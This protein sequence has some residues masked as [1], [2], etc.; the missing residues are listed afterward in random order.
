VTMLA[1]LH[2]I[3]ILQKKVEGTFKYFSPLGLGWLQAKIVIIIALNLKPMNKMIGM[4]ESLHCDGNK[5]D[6]GCQ[7]LCMER[8]APL[9]LKTFWNLQIFM[10]LLPLAFFHSF[11]KRQVEK[12]TAHDSL[13]KFKLRTRQ[14][15]MKIETVVEDFSIRAAKI[16]TLVV[17]LC[18]EFISLILLLWLQL[19]KYNVNLRNGFASKYWK[20]YLFIIPEKYECD[21][22]KIQKSTYFGYS[23]NIYYGDNF[24]FENKGSTPNGMGQCNNG[25]TKATCWTNRNVES[26]FIHSFLLFVAILTIV[27]NVME[28]IYNVWSYTRKP[29][30]RLTKAVSKNVQVL[31]KADGIESN[32]RK[33]QTKTTHDML[34]RELHESNYNLNR[35]EFFGNDTNFAQS[36]SQDSARIEPTK[37]KY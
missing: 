11:T 19:Q 37:A 24:K 18:V 30:K 16:I 12:V 6:V 26:T 28:L 15:N 29:A 14:V 8:Y 7:V 33:F 4:H 35:M 13:S 27:T 20:E 34:Q 9:T 31:F 10:T 21:L 23:W 5:G 17:Q 25:A 2:K 1:D 3:D 36:T 32:E 22:K